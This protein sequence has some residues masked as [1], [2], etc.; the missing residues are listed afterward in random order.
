MNHQPGP[1][2]PAHYELRIAGHLDEH[3]SAWFGALV[4]THE[5]DGTTT[6]RGKV[7]DQAELH[8]LLS[9]VRDLGATLISVTSDATQDATAAT[10]EADPERG[11][12]RSPAPVPR[13]SNTGRPARPVPSP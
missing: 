9:K 4:I 10:D 7:A 13:N 5:D 8:G 3:W 2:T 11:H 12:G 6:L 1:H